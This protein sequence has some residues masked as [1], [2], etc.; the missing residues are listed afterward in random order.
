MASIGL[1]IPAIAVATI[2]I[3]G[4][5]APR[6]R[7]DADGAARDHRR[8]LACSPSSR[9]A[10]SRSRAAC[11]WCCSR[12]SSSC[13][14]SLEPLSCVRGPWA[15]Q[16]AQRR[17]PCFGSTVTRHVDVDYLV[18]GAGA[19]G[20]AFTD[21]LI[22][23]ADV[24]VALVDRR[25]GAGRALARGLPVRAAAPVVHVL[26]RRVDAARR[27]RGSSRRDPRRG[28]T[29]GP[30]RPTI[31]R[32]LQRPAG[33]PDGR[34]R[35]GASSSRAASYVGGRQ[36]RLAGLGRALRGAG[37]VPDRRRPLPRPRHPGRVAAA[38]R[39][40]RRRA[41]DPGQRP[42][43]ESRRPRASTSSSARARPRPTR[44]SGCSATG[45]TPTRS[46][47]CVRAS[48]GCSTAP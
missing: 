8:G 33:G 14:S 2:W 5:L 12:R 39:R 31:V 15:D 6:P 28:C 42:R 37:A 19:T 16:M 3:D 29:S 41:G 46:A 32:L 10:P 26:R 27:R 7:A 35:P 13:R 25:H 23:H 47:G 34:L 17:R 38:V 20:M 1:T 21:A 11:T 4:P 45:W 43:P 22:D 40:G 9:A 36:L 18:V 24:R 48:R 30:T 44:A